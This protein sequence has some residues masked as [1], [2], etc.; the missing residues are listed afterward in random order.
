MKHVKKDSKGY[1]NDNSDYLINFCQNNELLLINTCFKYKQS[2][3]T[4]WEYVCIN[5]ETNKTTYMKSS[6]FYNN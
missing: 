1:K 3:L 2:H 4:T 6:R 5:K